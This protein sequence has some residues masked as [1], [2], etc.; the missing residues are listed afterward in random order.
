MGLT[1]LTLLLLLCKIESTH[2]SSI[3][4]HHSH[5]LL[6]IILHIDANALNIYFP[7]VFHFWGALMLFVA[8]HSTLVLWA[9]LICW[10]IS[11]ISIRITTDP[12]SQVTQQGNSLKH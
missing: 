4:L 9:W 11:F 2:Q 5:L 1:N 12:H 6:T 3:H 7:C 8:A 10:H